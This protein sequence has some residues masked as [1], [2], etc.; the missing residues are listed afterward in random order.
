MSTQSKILEVKYA[1]FIENRFDGD[2]NGENW[3]GKTRN[4]FCGLLPVM[5]HLLEWAE[6]FGKAEITQKD[7]EDLRG[8]FD[9]DPVVISTSCGITSTSI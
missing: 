6:E 1:Q 7:V 5:K 4:Y 8:S 3:K 2:K 9:E